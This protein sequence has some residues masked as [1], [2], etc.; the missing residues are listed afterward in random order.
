MYFFLNK[1]VASRLCTLRTTTTVTATMAP[2]TMTPTVTATAITHDGVAD[3]VSRSTKHVEPVNCAGHAHVG[4]VP[5]T[6][7]TAHTPPFEQNVGVHPRSAHS[8]PFQPRAHWH[9]GG[10][11]AVSQMPLPPQLGVTSAMKPGH[12]GTLQ[13]EPDQP[14][15]HMHK[16]LFVAPP[17]VPRGPHGGHVLGATTVAQ[18]VPEK[19]TAQLHTAVVPASSH[20]P[21]FWHAGAHVSVAQ[22][23]PFQGATQLQEGVAAP[24]ASAHVPDDAP[25]QLLAHCGNS[26]CE[27]VQ[28]NDC[29]STVQ[30]H[31]DPTQLPPLRHGAGQPEP[32]VV[33]PVDGIAGHVVD[34][35]RSLVSVARAARVLHVTNDKAKAA[36]LVAC[37]P[38]G[39]VGQRYG[40]R[41]A[42]RGHGQDARRALARRRRLPAARRCGCAA[43]RRLPGVVARAARRRVR[44]VDGARREGKRR[45][46]HCCRGRD[47]D[48]KPQLGRRRGEAQLFA[49]DAVLCGCRAR[50]RRARSRDS[51]ILRARAVRSAAMRNYKTTRIPDT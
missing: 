11:L 26:H 33:G 20:V 28:P 30:T 27:P 8:G 29:A 19:P 42:L 51:E 31:D 47:H 17:H 40:G 1:S 23:G 10:A 15:A 50:T 44:H 6:A 35:A 48:V 3:A 2:T 49:H 46:R 9:A 37:G 43:A 32:D 13:A 39:R 25:L 22:V 12:T 21:P 24:A 38:R 16:K 4:S 41:A 36:G 7:D 18:S 5:V 14:A 45:Q 34:P